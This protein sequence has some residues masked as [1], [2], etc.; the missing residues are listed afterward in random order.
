VALR[1]YLEK[2]MHGEGSVVMVGGEPGVGKSRIAGEVG[3][4]ASLK[5]CLV[6]AGSCYDR[7]D[8]VPFIQATLNR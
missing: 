1:A 8:S 5:G 6:L 2:A 4:E 7:E 3:V